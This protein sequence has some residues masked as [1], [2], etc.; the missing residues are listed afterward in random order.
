[1]HQCSCL[2]SYTDAA[3][4]RAI[5]AKYGIQLDAAKVPLDLPALAIVRSLHCTWHKSGESKVLKRAFDAK[6]SEICFVDNV[7]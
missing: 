1:M 3:V 6:P 7:G 5:K 4:R 2:C